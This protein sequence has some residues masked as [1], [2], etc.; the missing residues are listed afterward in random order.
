MPLF[1]YKAVDN[2]GNNQKGNIEAASEQDATQ[3]L[4]AKNYFILKVQ[5]AEQGGFFLTKALKQLNL[6]QPKIS[7]RQIIDFTRQFSSLLKTG[8]PYHRSLQI[9]INS[10]KNKLFHSILTQI[11]TEVLE[12][13][14][15]ATCLKK[16]PNSFTPMY[17]S[18][19]EAGEVGGNLGDLMQK[20]A[21]FDYNQLKIENR[22]RN[23][24]LYPI[25]MC[26]VAL[27]IIIFMVKF[28]LPKIIPIFDHFDTIL[29]LPTRVVIF[30]SNALSNHGWTIFLVFI[31]TLLLF[32]F[33]KQTE[34]GKLK[35]DIF[36]L[37]IPFYKDFL[38][39]ILNYRFIQVLATLLSSGVNLKE[40]L[41][42]C[43]RITGNSFYE[44]SI[45]SLEVEITKKGFSLSQALQKL[46]LLNEAL[47]QTIKVGE[48]SG[49]LPATLKQS[50]ENLEIELETALNK[51]VSL[52]EPMIILI[53]AL[54]VGFIILSVL[55]PMFQLN[56]LV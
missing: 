27:G 47:V 31:S 32:R 8:V 11:H 52:L 30:L 17:M 24:M 36:S 38:R 56:Q 19:V 45:Q 29:P 50:A 49:T 13:Q 7:Q 20:Q 46:Q 6:F 44:Q 23:A 35:L 37:K 18:L 53:M 21:E 10:E 15:L 4:Q 34:K 48:E 39:K 9:I 43:E 1:K 2:S 41:E 40:A 55:L 22:I 54:F 28:I 25:I 16:F 5:L 12:G 26:F 3:I 51:Y 33:W 14:P 42:I